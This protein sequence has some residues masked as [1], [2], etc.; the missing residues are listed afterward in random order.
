MTQNEAPAYF[1]VDPFYFLLD[2]IKNESFVEESD[3]LISLQQYK[4]A[5]LN[6]WFARSNG[7]VKFSEELFVLD[8]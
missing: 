4:I 3:L 6:K 1:P 2:T 5:E 8:L 7:F